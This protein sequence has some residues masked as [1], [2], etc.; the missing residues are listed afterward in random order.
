MGILMNSC[1][2]AICVFAAYYLIKLQRQ[3]SL[4]RANGCRPPKQFPHKEPILGLDLF[5][6]AGTLF[7]EN[8]YLPELM[9]RYHNNGRTFGTK[10]LGLPAINSV[11]PE[12]LQAVFS[13]RSKDWG[14][15]PIRLPA[16][17]PFC[18]R[19]FITT[20]GPAWEHS[21]ALL[22][23]SFNRANI[24]DLSTLEN[25][26]KITIGCIPR[27]GSSVDLQSLFSNLVCPPA[28]LP[29]KG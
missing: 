16:Q 8:R 18:G 27:D 21:R 5:F 7:K 15:E 13:S 29:L 3:R 20:D 25:C 23:P 26:L 12:N 4:A 14:V 19:G 24:A 11:A 2:A 22:K 1:V 28:F 17:D 10:S 6:K 9:Q